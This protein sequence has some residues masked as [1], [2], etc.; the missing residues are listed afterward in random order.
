[1]TL[2]ILNTFNVRFSSGRMTI[3]CPDALAV[4]ES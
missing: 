2:F 3:S 1:M 4:L